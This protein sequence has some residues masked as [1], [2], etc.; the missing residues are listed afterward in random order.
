VKKKVLFVDD[1]NV[2]CH[3]VQHL[4]QK[5]TDRF[6][7]VTAGNG[8]EALDVLSQHTVSLVITDLQMPE[9][10]GFAL[11]A[12]MSLHHPE[13]PVMIITAY[14]SPETRR[15]GL[16]EGAVGFIE[17]PVVVPDLLDVISETLDA[18]SEGGAFQ[19]IQLE[20]MAQLIEMAR[21]S[22]TLRVTDKASQD[23]GVLFFRDG[24]LVDARCNEA[25]GIP[26]AVALFGWDFVKMDIEETLPEME[27]SIEGGLD[28]VLELVAQQRV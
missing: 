1:D 14:G 22:C 3:S 27:N 13:V 4:S 6:I 12:Q 19:S 16:S 8:V 10:D 24:A 21:K 9:M 23:R 20:T 7:M 25:E 5:Y 11:L 17:K 15:K 18:Q 28:A 2:L 26:A